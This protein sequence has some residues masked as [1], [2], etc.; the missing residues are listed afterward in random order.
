MHQAEVNPAACKEVR[1]QAGGRGINGIFGERQV[2]AG[3]GIPD[4]N[5]VIQPANL[6]GE[7][8]VGR[9]EAGLHAKGDARIAAVEAC[10][11]WVAI[12]EVMVELAVAQVLPEVFD[13]TC[14]AA[15][16]VGDDLG[17]AQHD[18]VAA[19]V[20]GLGG[21]GRNHQDQ[22]Q[23]HSSKNGDFEQVFRH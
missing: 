15:V 4:V 1:H 20:L 14:F 10:A 11:A 9:L 13:A 6:V 21:R 2:G 3:L 8:G 12:Y 22:C 19:V 17:V 7:I 18:A 5:R 23:E 16:R